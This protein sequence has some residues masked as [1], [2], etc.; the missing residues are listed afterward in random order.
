MFV[1]LRVMALA[2]KRIIRAALKTRSLTR[3]LARIGHSITQRIGKLINA[4]YPLLS[5]NGILFIDMIKPR[6]LTENI[7][8][9]RRRGLACP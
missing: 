8:L 6:P 9:V 4:H 7:F 5:Y 3:C 2:Y 1:T